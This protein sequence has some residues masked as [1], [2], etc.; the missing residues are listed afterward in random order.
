[1]TELES[2]LT[3][4]ERYEKEVLGQPSALKEADPNALDELITSRLVTI[5]N[6]KQAEI[7]DEE[8]SFGV[9][10]YRKL[11]EKFVESEEK[12]IA[13]EPRRRKTSKPPKS[14]AEILRVDQ[15]EI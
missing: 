15:L 1:M 3:P 2:K 11:R 10:Y 13:E 6:K 4:S 14:V 12:K 5:F 9:R 7:T 8:L